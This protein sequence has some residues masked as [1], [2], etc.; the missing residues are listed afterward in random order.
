[1]ANTKVLRTNS[2]S[3]SF[4]SKDGP[5][6][7]ST[8]PLADSMSK[9]VEA[10]GQSLPAPLI[11]SSTRFGDMR[12]SVDPPLGR[13]L[14]RKC[15]RWCMGSARR[16]RI[17]STRSCSQTW[18]MAS[19]SISRLVGLRA[20][21]GLFGKGSLKDMENCSIVGTIRFL[22]TLN[23]ISQRSNQDGTSFELDLDTPAPQAVK[24]LGPVDARGEVH[25]QFGILSPEAIDAGSCREASAWKLATGRIGRQCQTTLDQFALAV[26][27]VRPVTWTQRRRRAMP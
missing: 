1:M 20:G 8:T 19:S 23:N 25:L 18:R 26:S 12:Y 7:P 2:S 15:V 22:L 16:A 3:P 9:N 6:A 14:R 13:R 5:S 27:S 10:T 24:G 21:F 11:S 17:I 4:G